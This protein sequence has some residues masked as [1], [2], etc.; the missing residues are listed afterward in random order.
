MKNRRRKITLALLLFLAASL[1]FAQRGRYGYRDGR[2]GVPDWDVSKELPNDV[3]TFARIEYYSD[4]S[5]RR[6]GSWATD[7]PDADLNLSFRLNEMTSLKVHPDGQVLRLTDDELYD[8]PFIYIVEPGNLVFSDEEVER[9]RRY[10]YNGGFLMIDDFWG[11]AEWYNLYHH[12][13]RV[14]PDREPR[15]IPFEHNIF[16]AIFP[17]EER[18][19]IPSIHG[20]YA[21]RT[22]ER[23]D[24]KEVHYKGIYDDHGRMMV[25][26][27]HNTDLGDGWEREGEDHEYFKQFSEKSA[28]PLAINI[29]FHSMTH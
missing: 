7:F 27:C 6:G 11:E 5:R 17:L 21:G 29:L 14:F 2:R 23:S 13:K 22:Y 8:Y 4:G 26:I 24:A 3:F 16:H 28:Y 25:I 15:S 18:P 1:C 20:F 12:I 9:L 19:Q 10:C